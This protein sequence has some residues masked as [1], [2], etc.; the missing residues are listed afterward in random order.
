MMKHTIWALGLAATVGSADAQLL[1]G[2]DASGDNAWN[3]DPGSGAASLLW[4]GFEV[5]GMAYDH[6]T[7]TVYAN[8]GTTLGYGT[9]GSGAPGNTVTITD[10]AGNVLSMVSLAWA[11]GALYGTRNIGEEAIYRID[12]ATGVA[13]IVFDYDDDL[14]DFGGLAFNIDDG[15]FYG[16]NDD[17]DAGR[18]LYS[19]DAFGN[20]TISLITPYPS[21]ETDIDGL[22]IG[23]GVAYLVEDEAG[24]TIHP[25][26]LNAGVYLADITSPM[27][28]SAVFSG[29]A[30]VVP[31]P[32]GLALL[33]LGGLAAT[34]RR[35]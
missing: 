4:S 26:D 25:F 19:I 15:M 9:L 18:G 5:W 31:A 10:D 23:G 20:G 11:N 3:V 14:F 32:A 22:A 33:G 6:T 28:T 24:D 16:T 27:T 12:P 13:T 17:P 21:G 2:Y 29:A 1:V 8:D 7:N 30:Y 35:R 34:R